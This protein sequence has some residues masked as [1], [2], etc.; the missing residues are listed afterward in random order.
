[1]KQ[2]TRNGGL[3]LMPNLHCVLVFKNFKRVG[4]WFIS[5]NISVRSPRKLIIF[6]EWKNLFKIELS[7][8]A[9]I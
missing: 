7:R 3:K 9:I 6:I 8:K 1:M 4:V 5:A 2:R